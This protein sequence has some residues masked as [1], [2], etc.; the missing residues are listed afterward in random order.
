MTSPEAAASIQLI[1]ACS[2][3][4]VGMQD[5]F[6]KPCSKGSD[7][8]VRDSLVQKLLGA[9]QDN[10][11][12]LEQK[13]VLRAG[14]KVNNLR[15]LT[16]TLAPNDKDLVPRTGSN[17]LLANQG[18]QPNAYSMSGSGTQIN[19]PGVYNESVSSMW[20]LISI[21]TPTEAY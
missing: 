8:R 7:E 17:S 14:D 6:Q 13:K 5:L 3:A 21:E 1:G 16:K 18:S 9:I 10:L 4:L 2:Q 15:Q 20:G 12:L 11:K 19:N